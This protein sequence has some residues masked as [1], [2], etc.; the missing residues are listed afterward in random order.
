MSERL[1]R[2]VCSVCD[3]RKTH[4]RNFRHPL[5]DMLIL[6]VLARLCGCGTRKEIIKFGECHLQ[7][8]QSLYGILPKGVPSEAT[9]CRMEKCIDE[10]AFA[11]LYSEFAHLLTAGIDPPSDGRPAIKAI[12]GKF[13]RGTTLA[14]GRW[15]DIVS[16]YDVGRGMATDTEAC[17]EK[18]NEIKATPRLLERASF[19]PGTV[20]T[21]DA[22]NCQTEIID[23]ILRKKAHYFI[24]LKANQRTL[25]YS[26]EDTLPGMTADDENH[27][28]EIGHGRIHER[29]CRVFYGVGRIS[30]ID[31][32]RG[33]CAVVEVTTHTTYK[34]TGEE[35]SQ[36]RY[37][38]TSMRGSAQ[39]MDYIS[40][41]HWGIENNQHWELDTLQGQDATKRKYPKAAR[42]LDTIQKIVHA[43][44]AY[45]ARKKLPYEI[46]SSKEKMKTQFKSLMTMASFNIGFALSMMAL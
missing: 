16:I 23:L 18:S 26:V 14:N 3:Y 36:T 21:A 25:R 38:I 40:R 29:R 32:F 2:L 9:L 37:Y 27:S 31:K 34:A 41:K 6:S 35:T 19:E 20:V 11:R 5:P 1:R 44:I 42:N 8:L 7:L 15:P 13:M 39:L 22:M 17:Q 33:V 24:A 28:V 4:K 45:T 43:I 10:D 46:S 12:D 30:G